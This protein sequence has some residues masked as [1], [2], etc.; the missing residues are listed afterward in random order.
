LDNAMIFSAT[1]V[2]QFGYIGQISFNPHPTNGIP[3]VPRYEI[4]YVTCLYNPAPSFQPFSLN[5]DNT[6][7][8]ILT[9]WH[10]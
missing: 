10:L 1:G 2:D 6:S 3:L 8:I 7:E 9:P 5:P 4:D